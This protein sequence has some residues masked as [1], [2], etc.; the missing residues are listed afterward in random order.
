VR[1]VSRT[2]VHLTA[3][4]GVNRTL[5]RAG[6][7]RPTRPRCAVRQRS[8]P[9]LRPERSATKPYPSPVGTTPAASTMRIVVRSGACVQCLT[10]RGTV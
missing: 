1:R 3:Y 10:P 4:Y 6:G 9:S 7:V 5:V 8:D 2:R